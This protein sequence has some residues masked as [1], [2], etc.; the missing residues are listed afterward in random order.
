MPPVTVVGLSVNVQDGTVIVR[1]AV[2]G[3]PLPTAAP[4]LLDVAAVT[5][6][7]VTVNVA[8]VAP[9][10]TVTVAGTVAAAVLLDVRFTLKPPV[11]AALPRVTVPVEGVP[12][13]TDVGLSETALTTG[14]LTVNVA[15]CF[16]VPVVA[17]IVGVCAV[18]TASVVTV[19]VV[20]VEPAG[21]VTVA[22]TV[23]ADVK[24]DESVTTSPPVGAT[25]LM[26]TVPVDGVPPVTVV[27]FRLSA[28]TVGASTVRWQVLDWPPERVPV[29][30][31]VTFAL[32]AVVVIV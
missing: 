30:V 20:D 29:I 6:V 22:G 4:I 8:E 28:L 9:P 32:T 15:V 31:A 7:V 16:A 3:V 10:A 24:L 5:A 25:P 2:T 21:T 27:G 13:G 17:V 26:V 11:G 14:G 23:A 19:K 1:V 12:P 18:A